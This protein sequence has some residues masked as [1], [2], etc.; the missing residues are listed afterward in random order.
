MHARFHAHQSWFPGHQ[1]TQRNVN[2]K[3]YVKASYAPK[4]MQ[5]QFRL[6][7][8]FEQHSHEQARRTLVILLA[9][10]VSSVP[11]AN[12][13]ATTWVGMSS[14]ATSPQRTAC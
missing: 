8:L 10:L 11:T 7:M 4:A 12:K 9:L 2:L 1:H 14:T 6:G 5:H 13:A 3:A